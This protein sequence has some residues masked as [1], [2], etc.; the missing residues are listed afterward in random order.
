MEQERISDDD[1]KSVSEH[2]KAM[3]EEMAKSKPRD[4]VLLSLM[5]STFRS[6]RVYIQNDAKSVKETLEIYPALGR[7]AMVCCL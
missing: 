7:L 3:T 2:I 5:K 6:R 4:H 1:P